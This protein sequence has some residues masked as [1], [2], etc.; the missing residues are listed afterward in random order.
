MPI[1]NINE[2]PTVQMDENDWRFDL[3]QTDEVTPEPEVVPEPEAVAEPEPEVVAEP[4]PE[5][6]VVETV[7][8]EYKTK[9]Y[10]PVEDEEKLAELLDKKYGY[11]KMKSEDK[12]LAFI[13]QQNPELDDNEIM[14]IAANDYGIGVDKPDEDDL[15]DSQVLD[16][17]KQDIA[18]KKLYTQAENYFAEQAN[19]IQLTSEDP[20]ELDPNYKTY[21]EQ[22]VAQEQLKKQQEQKYQETIKEVKSA[23][24]SISDYKITEE[25]DLDGSKFALEVSFKMDDKKQAELVAYAERYSPTDAEVASYTDTTTGKFDWKGYMGYMAEKAFE[26]DIRKAAIRQAL[27]QD[28]QQF[29]EKELKNSTLRNND[30]SAQADRKVDHVDYYWDKY[31]G[32]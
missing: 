24:K 29:I 27:A 8:P 1:D 14:F 32:R 13:K 25:I 18:R 9:K 20:L 6:P 15:T 11:K 4:I 30:V 10:V 19:Q 23:A 26:K 12:A 31:A 2:L 7:V 3:Y 22:V 17:K 28:R 16:L 21:K 5:P